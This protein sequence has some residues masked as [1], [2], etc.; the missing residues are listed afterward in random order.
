MLSEPEDRDCVASENIRIQFLILQNILCLKNI[1]SNCIIDT[2][3]N[4]KTLIFV[5]CVQI[6]LRPP[7]LISK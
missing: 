7:H 1:T 2:K 4:L 3:N 6:W 5:I